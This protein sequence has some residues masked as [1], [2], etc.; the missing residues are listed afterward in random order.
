MNEFSPLGVNERYAACDDAKTVPYIMTANQRCISNDTQLV[1]TRRE[2][3]RGE[4]ASLGGGA[5][6]AAVGV[7]LS[8]PLGCA[9]RD[10]REQS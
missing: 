6:S 10:C 5:A 7:N 1:T 3:S 4:T 2:Q 9:P 8:T